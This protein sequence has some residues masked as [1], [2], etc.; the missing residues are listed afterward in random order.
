MVNIKLT[1][2]KKVLTFLKYKH[3]ANDDPFQ[4]SDTQTY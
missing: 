3:I 4:Y 2:A 1:K